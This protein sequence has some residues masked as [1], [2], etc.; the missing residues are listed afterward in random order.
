MRVQPR[1]VLQL[2]G[3]PSAALGQGSQQNHHHRIAGRLFGAVSS[4]AGDMTAATKR[5]DFLAR[6]VPPSARGIV[7]R[8]F[9]GK[10]SPRAA[11]K[12]KCLDCCCYDRGEVVAC[13]VVLCPLHSY[14]PFQKSARKAPKSA[15]ADEFLE[16]PG[17]VDIEEGSP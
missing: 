12:A 7:E 5:A 8:A 14:R 10:A 3:A 2:A 9:V 13:T 6:V 4:R 16:T 11:I 1:H 17:I 15:R